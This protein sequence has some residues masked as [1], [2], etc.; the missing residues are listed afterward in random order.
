[1]TEMLAVDHGFK[2]GGGGG[3]TSMNESTQEPISIP[4]SDLA[5]RCYCLSPCSS[6]K[7]SVM[8][9]IVLTGKRKIN[10][11]SISYIIIAFVGN[12]ACHTRDHRQY[13]SGYNNIA[14]GSSS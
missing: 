8:E 10:D 2:I 13:L 12:P 14:T 5:V 1:M 3:G 6:V 4:P 9:A 7:S 11:Q